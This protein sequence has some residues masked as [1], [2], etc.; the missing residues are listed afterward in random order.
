M[1]LSDWRDEEGHLDAAAGSVYD[2]DYLKSNIG[3]PVIKKGHH[4]YLPDFFQDL[5]FVHKDN[6]KKRFAKY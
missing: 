4:A 6:S 5:C 3:I 2:L 1:P